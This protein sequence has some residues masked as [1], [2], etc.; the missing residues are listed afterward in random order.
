MK[1]DVVSLVLAM[2]AAAR[3]YAPDAWCL[4]RR[5]LGAGVRIGASTLVSQHPRPAVRHDAPLRAE[6]AD[7]E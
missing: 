4:L 7:S 2:A 3:A 6:G 5:L 1:S